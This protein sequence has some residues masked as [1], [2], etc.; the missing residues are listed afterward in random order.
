MK[1]RQCAL[2]WFL[3]LPLILLFTMIPG[4]GHAGAALWIENWQEKLSLKKDGHITVSMDL[5]WTQPANIHSIQLP[6]TKPAEEEAEGQEWEIV[7]KRDGKDLIYEENPKAF[8]SLDACYK[9]TEE[10]LT[11]F[12]VNEKDTTRSF[13]IRY[14]LPRGLARYD[15]FVRSALTIFPEKAHIAVSQFQLQVLPASQMT[16]EWLA[17]GKGAEEQ[18]EMQKLEEETRWRLSNLEEKDPVGIHL[19]LPLQAVPQGNHFIPE[20]GQHFYRE[21][22]A[23]LQARKRKLGLKPYW[24]NGSWILTVCLGILAYLAMV[25]AG[26]ERRLVKD[27]LSI[28]RFSPMLVSATLSPL[29]SAQTFHAQMLAFLQQN[30][31][32]LSQAGGDLLLAPG[33]KSRFGPQGEAM[34]IYEQKLLEL[35]LAHPS[36]QQWKR[37]KEENPGEVVSFI[38]NRWEELKAEKKKLGLGSMRAKSRRLLFG[39]IVLFLFGVGMTLWIPSVS[40]LLSVLADGVFLFLLAVGVFSPSAGAVSLRKAAQREQDRLKKLKAPGYEGKER[41]EDQLDGDEKEEWNRRPSDIVQEAEILDYAWGL[42]LQL[43]RKRLEHWRPSERIG[44]AQKEL[45]QLFLSEESSEL[46]FPKRKEDEDGKKD[47]H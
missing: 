15:D 20:A 18:I 9:K 31:L 2:A 30:R 29:I 16:G 47:K 46:W 6:M 13:R 27:R 23:L 21:D 24:K 35:Y 12:F 10:G 4:T 8:E 34:P 25:R 44:S 40:A 1:K 3:F 7:E 39:G 28:Q 43:D 11:L 45:I 41:K 26:A 36:L 22:Q 37:W 32:Q 5:T 19:Y 38:Q 17:L 33:E 14:E 42:I